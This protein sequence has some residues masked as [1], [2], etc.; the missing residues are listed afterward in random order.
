MT[1][2]RH[3]GGDREEDTVHQV[4]SDDEDERLLGELRRLAARLDPVPSQVVDAANGSLTWRNLDAELA[5]LAF[6]S[7]ELDASMA[8]VRGGGDARLLTFAASVTLEVEVAELARG[9]RRL[10]GRVVPAQPV[11]VEIRHPGGV[12]AADADQRGMFMVEGVPAGPVSLRCRL[13]EHPDQAVVET[14]WT[15]V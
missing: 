13:V 11:G 10:L 3:P 9:R 15:L 4:G 7:A 12:L 2:G 6:D 14:A 8:G 1:N 5:E